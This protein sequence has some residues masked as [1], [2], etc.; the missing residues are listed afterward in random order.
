MAESEQDL[1]VFTEGEHKSHI[2]VAGEARSICGSQQLRKH[3]SEELPEFDGTQR[4]HDLCKRCREKLNK[5]A[6]FW[7]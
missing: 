3:E 7:R 5:P 1:R 4:Y 2:Y 6:A